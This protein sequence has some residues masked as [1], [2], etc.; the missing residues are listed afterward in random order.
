MLCIILHVGIPKTTEKLPLLPNLPIWEPGN[1]F[2]KDNN[3]SRRP[4]YITATIAPALL[5]AWVF[6]FIATF[7][8]FPQK[9]A[10]PPLQAVMANIL[11]SSDKFY[12]EA[13]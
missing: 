5:T 13:K 9:D 4:D 11:E 3:H 2:L 12:K 7:F 10:L 6:A 8:A 1:T